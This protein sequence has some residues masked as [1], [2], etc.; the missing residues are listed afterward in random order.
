MKN[1]IVS[2]LVLTGVLTSTIATLNAADF[3]YNYIEASVSKIDDDGVD[4]SYGISGS[5][6]IAPN[7]NVLGSFDTA[8]VDDIFNMKTDV[9]QTSLGIGYHTSVGENTDVTTNIRYVNYEGVVNSGN[10]SL[11]VDANGYGLGAGVRHMFSEQL[12]GN[13]AIDHTK[14]D[15]SNISDTSVSLGGRFHF[16]ANTS[17]GMSYKS[18]DEDEV[19]GTLRMSFL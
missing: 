18:G 5:Y 12:E 9:N 2:M 4:N 6:D 19:S 8:R 13:A 15:D 10:T 1:K 17:A 7:V 11:V 16:N 14:I 3:S